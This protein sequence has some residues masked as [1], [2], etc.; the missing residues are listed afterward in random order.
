MF[1]ARVKRYRFRFSPQNSLWS[2]EAE[3]EERWHQV[4]VVGWGWGSPVAELLG[5]VDVEDVRQ[6][7][8]ELG[9]VTQGGADG[10]S[11]VDVVQFCRL[12]RSHDYN[13]PPDRSHD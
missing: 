7:G 5:Q 6:D 2:R 10:V 13:P 11:R 9:G 1:R 8:G 3:S 4:G 12:K